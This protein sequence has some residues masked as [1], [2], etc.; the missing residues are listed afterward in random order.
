MNLFHRMAVLWSSV[1]RPTVFR[2]SL[3]LCGR[4][5]VG[6]MPLSDLRFS[7]SDG[8]ALWVESIFAMHSVGGGSSRSLFCVISVTFS[9][10]LETH[11]SFFLGVAF[12]EAGSVRDDAAPP[13]RAH[14]VRGVFTS[15]TF[16][17]ICLIFRALG[18]ATWKS[19]SVAFR[20]LLLC[21]FVLDML[22][23]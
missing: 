5:V 10:D 9:P 18:A 19:Y 23:E 11:R 15:V 2:S 12:S 22:R 4:A 13:L 16:L 21:G 14:G 20:L 3:L 17:R 8:V 7:L 6:S 1:F